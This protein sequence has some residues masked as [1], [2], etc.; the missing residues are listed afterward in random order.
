[1][2]N[3]DGNVKIKLLNHIIVKITRNDSFIIEFLHNLTY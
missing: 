3:I 2:E 1:M